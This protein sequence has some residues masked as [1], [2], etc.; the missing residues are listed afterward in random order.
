MNVYVPLYLAVDVFIYLCKYLCIYNNIYDCLYIYAVSNHKNHNKWS[1]IYT[2]FKWF[3]MVSVACAAGVRSGIPAFGRQFLVASKAAICLC[4]LVAVL[5][6]FAKQSHLLSSVPIRNLVQLCTVW[7]DM[8]LFFRFQAYSLKYNK[9]IE[10]PQFKYG[11]S[12]KPF[13]SICCYSCNEWKTKV[14]KSST[15]KNHITKKLLWKKL[16]VLSYKILKK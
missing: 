10:W 5:M 11:I 8:A 1:W 15:R 7:Y 9:Y 2:K 16:F 3:T 4:C 6:T 14:R 12:F 13:T